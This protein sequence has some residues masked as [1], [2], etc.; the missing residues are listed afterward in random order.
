MRTTRRVAVAS[1]ATAATFLLAAGT[2]W[3][4]VEP[5]PNRVKPGKKVTVEFTPEHGC[6]ESVTTQM[7]FAVPKQVTKAK[8][9]QQDGWTTT[10]KGRKISFASDKVPDEETSFGI[11]FTAPSGKTLLAWKVIQRCQDGVNRWIEGPKGESPAPIV[12]VGKSPPADEEHG[13][14][15]AH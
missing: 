14:G 10:V 13:D 2:A 5:D 11:T 6:G 7:D 15:D 1:V 12:G 4:H 8:P 9:V 3:A